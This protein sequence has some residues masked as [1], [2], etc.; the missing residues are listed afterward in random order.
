MIQTTAKTA[1]L[2]DLTNVFPQG[3]RCVG[4]VLDLSVGL[5]CCI[6][7]K[8]GYKLSSFSKTLLYFGVIVHRAFPLDD[9]I[10]GAPRFG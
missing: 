6:L 5:S 8:K 3:L 2:T 10:V 4:T 9:L 1:G 7:L